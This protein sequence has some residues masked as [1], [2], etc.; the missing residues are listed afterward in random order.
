MSNTMNVYKSLYSITQFTNIFIIRTLLLI[1]CIGNVVL[2]SRYAAKNVGIH[3]DYDDAIRSQKAETVAI[4]KY[5]CLAR[6]GVFFISN[7][8]PSFYFL[9]SLK[10]K[11]TKQGYRVAL[12][13]RTQKFPMKS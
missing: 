3:R 2:D 4:I 8:T 9:R 7:T 10:H 5:E 12:I 11:I 1:H 13:I 6:P